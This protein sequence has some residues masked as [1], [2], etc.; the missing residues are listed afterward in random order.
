[1]TRDGQRDLDRAF[2]VLQRHV[3]GW[4]GRVVGRVRHPSSRW[5]RIPL[6]LAFIVSSLFWFLPVVGI[7]FL[8]LGLLLIAQDVPFLRGPVG[9]SA[10]W[11]ELKAARLLRW[12]RG[13]TR[14]SACQNG[15]S[16]RAAPG[17]DLLRPVIA[18]RRTA[19]DRGASGRVGWTGLFWSTC[20]RAGARSRST[21]PRN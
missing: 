18:D 4:L 7:E 13:R 2:D 14:S 12:W 19:E 9:R 6:G 21:G 17:P 16:S 1:M 5:W 10:L 15:L 20:G 3:P 11:L 8:P